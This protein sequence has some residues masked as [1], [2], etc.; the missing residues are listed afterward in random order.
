MDNQRQLGPPRQSDSSVPG[1]PTF[2]GIPPQQLPNN[3]AVRHP[4]QQHMQIN[5]PV[6]RPAN[7]TVSG[8]QPAITIPNGPSALQPGTV[9]LIRSPTGELQLVRLASAPQGMGNPQNPSGNGVR[10]GL[11][12][13]QLASAVR[14]PPPSAGMQQSVQA[15]QNSQAHNVQQMGNMGPISVPSA[16]PGHHGAHGGPQMP[17]AAPVMQQ[18]QPA[19]QHQQQPPPPQHQQTGG[20]RMDDPLNKAKQFFNALLVMSRNQTPTMYQTA[21]DLLQQLV[22]AKINPDMFAQR[23]QEELKSTPQP[24][25]APLLRICLAQLRRGLADGDFSIEGIDP[26]PPAALAITDVSAVLP[27][28]PPPSLPAPVISSRPVNQERPKSRPNSASTKPKASKKSAS[29]GKEV[30]VM[31]AASVASPG[32]GMPNQHPAFTQVPPLQTPHSKPEKAKT[33]KIPPAEKKISAKEKKDMERKRHR[34]MLDN[35]IAKEEAMAKSGVV[36][37]TKETKETKE[38][39][40]D[41]DELND[42]AAMGG[43]NL[44]EESAKLATASEI[45]GTQ[46][47]SVDDHAFIPGDSIRKRVMANLKA[48]GQDEL[49]SDVMALISHAVEARIRN[50][51]ERLNVIAEHRSESVRGHSRYLQTHDVRGQLKFMEELDRVEKRKRDEEEKETLLKAAKS[52][53]KPEDPE[54]M[55]LKMKAKEAQTKEQEDLRREE[56]NQAAMAALGGARKRPRLDQGNDGATAGPSTSNAARSDLKASQPYRPRIKRATLRD[57]V[58]MAETDAKLSKSSL[59]YGLLH[60][61]K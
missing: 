54:H 41:D 48:T 61:I 43:V 58:F 55:K 25:L 32:G 23:L 4:N 45:V 37:V 29:K 51:C 56:A 7:M 42:V 15:L 14:F 17:P 60:Q 22:D 52:R 18:R 57:V 16:L 33:P 38:H 53:N 59:L 36:T 1:N 31:A 2:N 44:N 26:P 30:S 40:P 8:S 19:P 9:Y 3:F 5:G 49:P 13:H 6:S 35:E 27:P 34:E 20:S 46:L 10:P 12:N 50:C 28:S 11:P 21:R 24:I 47:R 39:K